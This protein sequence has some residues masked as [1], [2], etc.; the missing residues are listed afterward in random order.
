[1]LRILKM[2]GRAVVVPVGVTGETIEGLLKSV[3]RPDLIIT[4]SVPGY[5]EV[6]GPIIEGLKA[7]ASAMGARFRSF[8]VKKGDVEVLVDVYK[9]L[10]EE[11]PNEVYLIGVTGSRYLLP[12]LVMVLLKYWR[13]AKAVV[14]LLHGVEG[15]ECEAVPLPG[16]FAPSMRL[17]NTQIKLLKIIYSLEGPISGKELIQKYGFTRSVYYVLADMERKG[18][19][20]VRRNK[21]EKTLPGRLMYELLRAGEGAK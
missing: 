11:R 12:L 5:E 15:E 4:V 19:L 2:A 8:T 7:A 10:L 1:M 18:L 9:L 17:S 6:K 20:F 13:D 21:I 16:F 3:P 14:Y